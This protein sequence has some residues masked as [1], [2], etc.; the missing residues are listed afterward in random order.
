MLSDWVLSLGNMH[1]RFLHD[2]SWLD[3]SV[4]FSPE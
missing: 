4:L 3:D 2:F 1:A